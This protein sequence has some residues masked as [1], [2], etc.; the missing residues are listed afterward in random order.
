[1]NVHRK[2]LPS[3]PDGNDIGAGER[4]LPWFFA[5]QQRMAKVMVLNRSWESALTDSVLGQTKSSPPTNV[6]ILMDPPYLQEN[7]TTMYPSDLEGHPDKATIDSYHWSVE[8]G[9]KYRI[10][11]CCRVGDFPVPDGWKSRS[12]GFKGIKDDE[13]RETSQDMLMFSP[14][15]L[16]HGPT[17]LEMGGF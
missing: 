2:R 12:R 4:L 1:M 8:H 7:R 3:Q 6:G 15:A 14:A 16:N 9:G 17:Q 5:L 10:V 13:R 11:Y